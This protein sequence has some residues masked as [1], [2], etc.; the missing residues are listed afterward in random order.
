MTA[1]T[2]F[3]EL[4]VAEIVMDSS[5]DEHH[6]IRPGADVFLLLGLVHTLFDEKL[7][8]LGHLASHVNG[9][10]E[11]EAAVKEFAPEQMAVRSGIDAQ[12]IRQLARQLAGAKVARQCMAASVL[13]RRN[14]AR[15]A[16][17]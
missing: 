5:V 2:K 17:G 15:S 16:V 7:V 12:S 1:F 3:I 11:V 13:A 8:Q 9:V 10:A 14:T 4:V 6:F